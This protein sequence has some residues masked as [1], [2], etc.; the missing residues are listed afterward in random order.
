MESS[1]GFLQDDTTKSIVVSLAP[2]ERLIEVAAL[3]AQAWDI[4]PDHE[5]LA[6]ELALPGRL[7]FIATDEANG[8]LLGA[9]TAT[10]LDMS[11]ATSDDTVVSREARGRGVGTALLGEL[12]SALR[13][14]G[15][16]EVHGQTS[17]RKM[18]QL[19]FFLDR[20]FR[21]AGMERAQGIPWF[22]DGDLV[23]RTVLEIP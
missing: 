15:I 5:A 7:S 19:G 2:A 14:A 13:A 23:F 4:A 16:R 20:G 12:V 8:P 22:N 9:T 18:G 3:A 1:N 10:L 6:R 21:V 11:R 17:E